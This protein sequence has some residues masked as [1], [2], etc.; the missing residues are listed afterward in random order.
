[1]DVFKRARPQTSHL[2]YGANDE[3]DESN[4]NPELNLDVFIDEEDGEEKN[5]NVDTNIG[6]EEDK[7]E[8]FGIFRSPEY[9]KNPD[10]DRN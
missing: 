9:P 7:E 3:H 4:P 10:L 2:K 6:D 1:M 8:I 5:G